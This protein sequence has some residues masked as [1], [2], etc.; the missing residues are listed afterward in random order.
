MIRRPPRSTLFPYTT[1][2]RSP[3]RVNLHD[4][5]VGHTLVLGKTGSGKSVLLALLAAQFRRYPEAQ[6]FAFDVGYS[7][8]ALAHAAGARHY[9]LAAGRGDVL[10]FPPLARI[11]AAP[12]RARAADWVETLFGLPGVALTPPLRARID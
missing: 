9:D 11:D 12:E 10:C 5:D 8:W 4:S 6:V 1:L 2:F 3:F 7:M